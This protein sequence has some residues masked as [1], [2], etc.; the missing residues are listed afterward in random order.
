MLRVKF[1][2]FG[3]VTSMRTGVPAKLV[4]FSTEMLKISREVAWVK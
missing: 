3:P 1:V 4:L 2:E